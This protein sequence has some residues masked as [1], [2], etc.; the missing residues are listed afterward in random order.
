MNKQGDI[1]ADM[2]T[3]AS[4]Y[5]AKYYFEINGG[6]DKIAEVMEQGYGVLLGFHFDYDEWTDVPFINP[7]SKKKIGH[8]VAG[9][10]YVLYNGVKALVIEDS[11]GH[12]YGKGGR[13]IIT[14]S[15]LTERCFYAGYITSLPNF[16]FTKTLRL[17]DRG[18]DVKMLQTKLKIVSDG[19]FGVKTEQAVKDFQVKNGLIPDGIVGKRTNEKLNQ[20]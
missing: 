19:I 2:T 12:L 8:G 1:T 4:Q 14:E 5:K 13:R 17:G 7:N 3:N 15:F 10:D 11:W 16:V 6:I 18:I 9:V 20:L